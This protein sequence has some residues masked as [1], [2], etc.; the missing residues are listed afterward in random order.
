MPNQVSKNDVR[1]NVILRYLSRRTSGFVLPTLFVV[2][3]SLV[4]CGDGLSGSATGRNVSDI[5]NL[6]AQ[7][8]RFSED[9]AIF[10]DLSA[11]ITGLMAEAGEYSGEWAGRIE[12]LSLAVSEEIIRARLVELRSDLEEIQI[13][14][15]GAFDESDQT[16]GELLEIMKSDIEYL[17]VQSDE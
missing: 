8:S 15:Q 4:A 11:E 2:L 14:L 3:L 7:L 6:E 17:L 5:E 10:N 1:S 12:E 13:S 16:V 9:M